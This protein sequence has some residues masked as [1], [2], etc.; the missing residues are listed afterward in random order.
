[1]RRV[2]KTDLFDEAFGVGLHPFLA[3][4]TE[5]FVGI[6]L[7][8]QIVAKA[9][10]RYPGMVTIQADV[11]RLPFADDF[12]DLIISNSTLDHF[13]TRDQIGVALAELAR[14][15]RPGG[16][17]V[18]TL[19][20][21]ENPIIALRSVIP[22]QLL[23]RLGVLPYHVGATY[24]PRAV[25]RAVRGA[26]FSVERRT[27]V[28]HCPRVVAVAVARLLERYASESTQQRFVHSLLAWESLGS[29]PIRYLS[30]HFVA[31]LARKPRQKRTPVRAR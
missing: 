11:R 8:D 3:G 10:Q 6:D 22:N 26:G 17:L 2:L 1:M 25:T 30:G 28:M 9:G 12:F 20:N 16:R 27:A 14:V 31:L 29:L 23:D 7:S 21:L 19:D 24:G 18:L 15:T 13:M 4:Q 5:E